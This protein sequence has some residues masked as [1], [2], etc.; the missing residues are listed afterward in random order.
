M[1]AYINSIPIQIV[2]SDDIIERWTKNWVEYLLIEVKKIEEE[3][4]KET[5]GTGSSENQFETFSSV[6]AS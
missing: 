1:H 2:D 3:G 6:A 4:I 5:R